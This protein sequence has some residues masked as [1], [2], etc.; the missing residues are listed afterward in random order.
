LL[1]ERRARLRLRCFATLRGFLRFGGAGW[2]CG[3]KWLLRPATMMRRMIAA[4][5]AHFLPSR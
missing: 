3:Q 5:R 2:H 4:Q 1:R